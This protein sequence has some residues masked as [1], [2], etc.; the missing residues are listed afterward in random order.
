[1]LLD[2]PLLDAFVWLNDSYA[3]PVIR[4]NQVHP[5][6]GVGVVVR[7]LSAHQQPPVGKIIQAAKPIFLQAFDF[8]APPP[9]STSQVDV[10]PVD[11]LESLR[12]S[13]C[14]LEFR[15]EGLEP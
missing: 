10:S 6:L 11:V 7:V 12:A 8:Y 15:D 4:D 13:G 9:E 5:G 3:S 14:N 1:V 2:P